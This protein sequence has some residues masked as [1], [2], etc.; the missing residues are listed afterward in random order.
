LDSVKS[1][2][3]CFEITSPRSA[4]SACPAEVKLDGRL[5]APRWR[6]LVFRLTVPA[7][8]DA[9]SSGWRSNEPGTRFRATRA[10][11][12]ERSLGEVEFGLKANGAAMAASG[13]SLDRHGMA[14]RV[15]ETPN[16]E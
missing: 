6:P 4:N 15:V 14:L 16:Y 12:L 11:A 13:V 8:D 1:A 10:V 5:R 9:K 2:A 3:H 7:L